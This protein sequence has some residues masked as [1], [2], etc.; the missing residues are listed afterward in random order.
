MQGLSIFALCLG[1]IAVASYSEIKQIK[2]ERQKERAIALNF[3]QYRRA[4]NIYALATPGFSGKINYSD[5]NLAKSWKAIHPWSNL[6][7]GGNCYVFGPASIAEILAAKE[8]LNH[9]YT[10]GV[11]ENG[12]LVTDHGSGTALPNA[13]PNGN[14][15]SVIKL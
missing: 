6:V 13:I 11:K 1:L 8:L 12:V 3:V 7:S 14:L 5:L 15:V 4:V 2:A 9:S 10:I